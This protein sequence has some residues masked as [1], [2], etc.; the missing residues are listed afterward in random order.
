[1]GE[2]IHKEMVGYPV[3]RGVD[4]Y[5]DVFGM[6]RDGLLNWLKDKN[7]VLDVS[8]GGGLLRK[9]IDIL[10]SQGSFVSSVKIVSLDIIYATKKGFEFAKYATHLAFTHL[11]VTPTK[12]F[13]SRIDE[14]FTKDAVGG[15]F[16]D[17]PFPNMSFDAV[18]VSYGFGI[19]AKSKSQMLSA[20]DEVYRLLKPG[21]EAL[22]SV[23]FDMNRGVFSNYNKEQSFIY[24]I[25]DLLIPDVRLKRSGS[26][27]YLRIRKSIN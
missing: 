21:G 27:S 9:E 1:M 26:H 22:V 3:N 11:G 5:A 18:L 10:K 2:K 19:H 20:Y 6:T 24:T 17:H 7:M 16:T 8:S 14:S 15:S 25:D 4:Q 12:N 13:I 23:I